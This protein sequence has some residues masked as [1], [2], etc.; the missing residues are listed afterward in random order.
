MPPMPEQ[1]RDKSDPSTLKFLSK[2]LSEIEAEK[3]RFS[4]ED[5]KV[6]LASPSAP[7]W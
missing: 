6:R 4:G 1:L 3:P 5:C 2:L 7:K